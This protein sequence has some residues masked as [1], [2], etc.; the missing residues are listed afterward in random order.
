M[1]KSGNLSQRAENIRSV[2]A[3]FCL[4][5][6]IDYTRYGRSGRV[7]RENDLA[8]SLGT[9]LPPLFGLPPF[10]GRNG[11]RFATNLP[12]GLSHEKIYS[13]HRAHTYHLRCFQKASETNQTFQIPQKLL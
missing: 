2:A 3:F 9:V 7:D 12:K 8:V 11:G 13:C 1:W 10:C 4:K 6:L 5:C